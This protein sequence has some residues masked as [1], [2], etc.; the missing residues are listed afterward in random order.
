[1][2]S[3]ASTE[4][5]AEQPAVIRGSAAEWT[6]SASLDQVEV[7]KNQQTHTRKMPLPFTID[8]WIMGQY[9]ERLQYLSL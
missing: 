6:I 2:N 9:Y 3:A 7:P 5:S 4:R 1:M 8:A